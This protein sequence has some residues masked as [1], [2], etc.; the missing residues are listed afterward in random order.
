M[1]RSMLPSRLSSMLPL[2]LSS[3]PPSRASSW[4]LSPRWAAVAGSLGLAALVAGP[5]ALPG[6]AY[7]PGDLMRL[8]EGKS[9]KHCKLQDADLMHADLRDARLQ[10]A[11]LQR[12]NLSRAKLDGA[13]MTGADLRHTS[14][15]G[16]SLRGADLRG[17]ILEGADLRQ[18]DL[19][20]CL[21]DP[22]AL[23]RTHWD[24]ATGIDHSR[25]L[26]HAELH[27]AGVQAANQG[28]HPEAERFFGAAIRKQPLAAISWMA[29][30]IS[31][32]EQGHNELAARD[33]NYAAELYASSGDLQ[34]A[35]QLKRAATTLITPPSRGSSGN[36]QGIAAV[37][38]A[39][40]A[41]QFLAPLAAK[42][43]LPL[44]F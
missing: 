19:S 32:G 13:L 3:M 42:A 21:L 16:A 40:T 2:R 22:G 6:S 31:R 30:A 35:E 7:S 44:P 23:A 26:S 10:N 41:L 39:M 5:L 43:F 18:A 25:E 20:G 27:N 38:G 14:F 33:F 37:G 17:A 24:Q 34:Q 4:P 8:L 28:R 29:R 36:G 15:N 12:A 11:H 1:L 9:C